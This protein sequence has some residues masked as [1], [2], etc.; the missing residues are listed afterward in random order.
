MKNI[1]KEKI[2]QPCKIRE[3]L[4]KS[5]KIFIKKEWEE[6]DKCLQN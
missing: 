4:L 6:V 5:Y 1:Y 2:E 3:I